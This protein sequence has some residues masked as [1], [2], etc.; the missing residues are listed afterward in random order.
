MENITLSYDFI[1][2]YV[3]FT[4]PEYLQ[5]YVYIKYIAEKDGEIPDADKLAAALDISSAKAEFILEYWAS[6]GELVC[7]NEGYKLRTNSGQAV[8]EAT[9]TQKIK[10]IK[11]LRVLI[12]VLVGLEDLKQMQVLLF[13]KEF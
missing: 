6:R 12:K 4:K 3:R 5:V 11:L 13:Q 2:K 8:A 9:K 1:D 10:R 7:D